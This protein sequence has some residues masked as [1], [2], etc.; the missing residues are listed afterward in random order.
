MSIQLEGVME[1]LIVL[2]QSCE[3]HEFEILMIEIN[4]FMGMCVIGRDIEKN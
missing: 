4:I 3:F 2:F 1:L